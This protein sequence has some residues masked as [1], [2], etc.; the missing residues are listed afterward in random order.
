[1]CRGEA[2]RFSGEEW[3]ELG[4]SALVIGF[5]FAWVM[6]GMGP[7]YRLGFPLV[8]GMMLVAV[9][10]AFI[11]HELAHKFVAQGYG[12][13]A[14]YRMWETGL[15]VAFFLA[16]ALGMVFAAPGAVYISNGYLS[17]RDNGLIS[18]AGPLT[19]IALAALFLGLGT[20]DGIYAIL[21][22]VGLK[23]NAWLA[24]FN[25]IPFGP[26]DGSK[27]LGWSPVAWAAMVLAALAFL[28]L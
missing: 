6:R 18:A 14:E 1:M 8:L 7:F 21:G 19:N 28:A 11:L 10:S 3:K 20:L 22:A 23:V 12:C 17:R 15:I 9:G 13:W 25:M 24:L 26:L 16:V 27:V 2:L 4:I 5:S